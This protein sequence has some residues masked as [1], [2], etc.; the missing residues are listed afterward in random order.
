MVSG[1]TRVGFTVFVCAWWTK[2][3]TQKRGRHKRA[4]RALLLHST[5]GRQYVERC[6]F[7][8]L[9]INSPF[10]FFSLH[11][12]LQSKFHSSHVYPHAHTLTQR[13]YCTRMYSIR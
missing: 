4:G 9:K 11:K 3:R 2:A 6:R 10:A 13:D 1:S 12:F 8:Q 7:R 5:M